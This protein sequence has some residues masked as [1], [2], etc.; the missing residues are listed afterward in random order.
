LSEETYTIPTILLIEPSSR[1]DEGESLE[2]TIL[3]LHGESENSG[4]VVQTHDKGWI[5]TLGRQDLNVKLE[6]GFGPGTACQLSLHVDD[7]HLAVMLGHSVETIRD[8]DNGAFA[9]TSV[10]WVGT[11]DL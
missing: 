9:S 3:L 1:N 8:I 2:F 6:V 7:L 4:F 11:N 5:V 10:L